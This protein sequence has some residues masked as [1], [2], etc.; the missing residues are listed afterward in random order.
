MIKAAVY[1]VIAV[2]LL[3]IVSTVFVYFAPHIGWAFN[4]VTSRSMEPF[5]PVNSL[6]IAKP[7]EMEDIEVGDVILF[8]P[9]FWNEGMIAHRVAEIDPG[10][11]INFITHGDANLAPDSN[12][13][14]AENLYGKVILTVSN[15]GNFINFVKET[16]G[17]IVMIVVPSLIVLA[18]YLF[19]VWHILTDTGKKKENVSE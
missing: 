12:R 11:P 8:N 18:A 4:S 15:L 9:P 3:V 7:A 13:V 19:S 6:I 17:F 1:F 10:P 2:S 14:R 16:A 5:I